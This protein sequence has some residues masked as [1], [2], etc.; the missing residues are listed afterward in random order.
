MP[1]A[2]LIQFRKGTSTQWAEADAASETDADRLLADGEPGF[3]T[4]L[5]I[6]KIG[7]GVTTWAELPVANSTTESTGE[8][9]TSSRKDA[10]NV[11][12]GMLTEN[13]PYEGISAS[14]APT[15]G[16]IT[17][18]LVG[19]NS[20]DTVAKINLAVV[21][22]GAGTVPT[23][24]KAGLANSTGSILAVTGNEKANVGL[25]TT[26]ILQLSLAVPYA[27]SVTGGYYLVLLQVGTWG[28]TNMTLGRMGTIAASGL[29]APLSGGL[30]RVAIGGNAQTDLPAV[31]GSL[32]S[33]GTPATT[34]LFWVSCS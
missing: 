10:M 7:D 23:L 18:H 17:K 2:D 14:T 22:P 1:R 15:P 30:R 11:A 16:T 12:A 32:P 21:T 24:F 5:K 20:G 9:D 31:S 25:I 19:L 6:F 27:V 28:T 33:N 29:S 3:D 8:T 26:G 4:D 13:F 34:N